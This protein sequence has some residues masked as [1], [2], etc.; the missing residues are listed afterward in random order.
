MDLAL[1]HT[2]TPLEAFTLRRLRKLLIQNSRLVLKNCRWGKLKA[3]CAHLRPLLVSHPPDLVRVSGR[4]AVQLGPCDSGFV[5]LA[6]L[7]ASDGCLF[8]AKV[9]DKKDLA[10][11][12]LCLL[13]EFYPGGDLHV[14]CQCQPSDFHPWLQL[15][16]IRFAFYFPVIFFSGFCVWDLLDV[17]GFSICAYFVFAFI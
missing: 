1:S 5:Y 3:L 12:W 15:Y 8:A 10:S 13:T 11:W 2:L 17:P 14:L 7:K 9:M 16:S 6:E 4:L